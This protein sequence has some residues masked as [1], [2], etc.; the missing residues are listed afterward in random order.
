MTLYNSFALITL[1]S[2]PI[3]VMIAQTAAPTQHG[4]PAPP[5]P[6]SAAQTVPH[7]PLTTPQPVAPPLPATEPAAFGQPMPQAGQPFLS[8]GAG[9]PDNAP[10][11]EQATTSDNGMDRQGD[12]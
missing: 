5:S 8:P 10:A 2:A 11:S 6:P 3:I 4:R 1:V 9:L 7:Q 12:N